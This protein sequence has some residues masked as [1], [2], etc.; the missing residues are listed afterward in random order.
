MSPRAALIGEAAFGSAS[1]PVH[2]AGANLLQQR[3][4]A[5]IAE[6]RAPRER[7]VGPGTMAGPFMRA[8]HSE[9]VFRRR[10]LA[11]EPTIEL[12]DA[13]VLAQALGL[14]VHG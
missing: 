3:P 13:T 4:A 9:R 6:T 12:V 5:H 10:I 2:V 7:P 1:D 11:Q 14:K 8:G